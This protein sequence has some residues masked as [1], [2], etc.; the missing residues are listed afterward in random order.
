MSCSQSSAI[1]MNPL[2]HVCALH[3]CVWYVPLYLRRCLP[4]V[5][6][7]YICSSNKEKRIWLHI[8]HQLCTHVG[9]WN[10][11]VELN[12]VEQTSNAEWLAP[13]CQL[14]IDST[15]SAYCTRTLDVVVRACHLQNCCLFG[16]HA[17]AHTNYLH[18][19]PDSVLIGRV[20]VDCN[21]FFFNH[22]W[23]VCLRQL[24]RSV[25]LVHIPTEQPTMANAQETP[26]FQEFIS[27]GK[28]FLS[29]ANATCYASNCV[30]PIL[31]ALTDVCGSPG[32][33]GKAAQH[34]PCEA[35]LFQRPQARRAI[36]GSEP[37]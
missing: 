13:C 14:L 9:V 7:S 1:S 17:T 3:S 33:A 35:H 36:Q 37:S 19:V 22:F 27:D 12:H 21:H 2:I 32:K 4:N 29:G 30:C 31:A 8:I 10:T 23:H 18:A 28:V 5:R 25:Q 34:C 11:R 16:T 24:T 15:T 26:S 20:L 6:A